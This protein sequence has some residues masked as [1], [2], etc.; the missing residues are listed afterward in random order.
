MS[1]EKDTDTGILSGKGFE[2][3]FGDSNSREQ[4]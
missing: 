3:G 4:S 1:D 2:G